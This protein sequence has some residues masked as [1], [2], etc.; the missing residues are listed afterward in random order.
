MDHSE[1]SLVNGVHTTER[2][3]FLYRTISFAV[4]CLLPTAFVWGSLSSLLR[5]IFEDETYTH[6]PL[7]PLVSVYLIYVKRKSIFTNVS[8]AWR[9]G[10]VVIACG[11]ACLVLARLNV[12]RLIPTNQD[13]LVMLG[14]VLVWLGAFP[15]LF[16]NKAFRSAAFPLLFLVFMVPVPQP[17]LSQ[18]IFLLQAGSS[19]ATEW[20]YRLLGVPFFRQG[21]TFALPGVT[22][23]VA[24]ECSGIRSTLAL[25]ICSVL[26]S[27]LFLRNSRKRIL[28]CLVAIPIAIVKNGFRIASLSTLAA[29]VNPVFLTGP[30]HHKGGGLFFLFALI[31]M[32]LLLRFLQ[33]SENRG[34]YHSNG[35]T[36]QSSS[37]IS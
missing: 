19:K 14:F 3:A 4:L 37:V 9:V 16:G 22:I 12:W 20:D 26:A 1:K 7:I 21:F 30:I 24:E 6:I 29:Y 28:L 18:V 32:V 17:L 5:L 2:Y 10:S 33:K 15:L 34:P 36:K 27:H 35:L 11:V 8:Y 25:L 31:P 13:S 23:R